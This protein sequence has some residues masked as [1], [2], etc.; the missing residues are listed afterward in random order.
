[1]HEHAHASTGAHALTAGARWNPRMT[2]CASAHSPRPS[3]AAHLQPKVPRNGKQAQTGGGGDRE[4]EHPRPLHAP[5]SPQHPALCRA[6]LE[7]LASLHCPRR[8]P[9][10]AA[11]PLDDA[12]RREKGKI[13]E[14]LAKTYKRKGP[15]RG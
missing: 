9:L 4:H 1:M 14:L 7:A 6:P 5:A 8:P 3:R 11:S 2:A 13:H 12:M 15:G 10:Y